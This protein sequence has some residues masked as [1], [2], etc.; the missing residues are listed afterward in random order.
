M[1]A[2]TRRRAFVGA[3]F[4]LFA[5]L[6][7]VPTADA[8]IPPLR[9]TWLFGP[10]PVW[11]K[12]TGLAIFHALSAPI[13]SRFLTSFRVSFELSESSGTCKIRPALRYSQDG[14]SWSP[15]TA[16][17]KDFLS[18]EKIVWGDAYFEPGKLLPA[19][20]PKFVQFGVE[21]SGTGMNLCNATLRVEPKAAE[22][23]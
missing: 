15:A 6:A 9:Q 1:T 8:T 14:T 5:S 16:L 2:R 11:T 20:L 23:K 21:V 19:P 4:T 17:R 12:A 13:E 10:S 18:E 22:E 3:V 7:L